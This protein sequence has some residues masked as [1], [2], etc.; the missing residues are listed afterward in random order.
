MTIDLLDWAVPLTLAILLVIV[1]IFACISQSNEIKELKGKAV[2]YGYAEYN[3][4][5]G[6]WGWVTPAQ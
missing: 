3:R 1:S 5:N 2:S 4:T 6:N